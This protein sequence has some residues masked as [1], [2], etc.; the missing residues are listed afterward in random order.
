MLQFISFGSGSCGNCSFLSNGRDAVLIDAGVGIRR[1]KK[2]M[3][4]YGLRTSLLRGLLVTHDHADHI[5]AAGYVSTD[6]NLQVYTT[7]LVHEGMYRNYHAMRKVEPE[8]RM[9]IEKDVP[10]KLGSLRITAFAI[11]H[12]STENVGY[13]IEW[14]DECFCL[15]TDVGAPTETVRQYIGRANYLVLEANYD[16]EMLRTGPYPQYLKDRIQSGTGHLCNEQ[17]AQLLCDCFH[18]RLKNVWLCHLSEENNHPE[19]A[20]KTVEMHLRSYG[21]V[22]GKDFQLEVL[23]RQVPTGPWTL[24][25]ERVEPR[26][27]ELDI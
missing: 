16:A 1:L 22:A 15:M 24:G 8:R 26:Q 11:P 23:R 14:D 10:F 13:M 3:R 2:W 4:E 27:L 12:D 17:T 7:A 5:K 19:L 21:I 25:E 20:R 18:E 6:Y 9:P